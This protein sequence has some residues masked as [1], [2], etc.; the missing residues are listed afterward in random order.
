MIAQNRAIV[1]IGQ[2]DCA[3]EDGSDEGAVGGST[4]GKKAPSMEGKRGKL[5][6]KE[7]TVVQREAGRKK[8]EEQILAL[9]RGSKIAR[10]PTK[11]EKRGKGVETKVQDKKRTNQNR[12][13]FVNMTK[14]T[15]S[16]KCLTAKRA[17]K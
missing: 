11:E 9:A 15:G 1:K 5:K 14:L 2:M 4:D 12:R 10:T 17:V 3:G 7:E 8:K 13:P 16:G 6:T